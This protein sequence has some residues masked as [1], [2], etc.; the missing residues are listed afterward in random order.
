MKERAVS[1]RN[2]LSEAMQG[3][4]HLFRRTQRAMEIHKKEQAVPLVPVTP[5]TPLQPIPA[6]PFRAEE[7]LLDRA[8]LCPSRTCGPSALLKPSGLLEDVGF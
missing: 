7:A 8:V 2:S 3:T 5:H 6:D 4:K 1:D